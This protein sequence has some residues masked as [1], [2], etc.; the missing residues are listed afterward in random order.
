MN[1]YTPTLERLKA[2]AKAQP[3][4][5]LESM[6]CMGDLGDELDMT[7]IAAAAEVDRSS[8]YKPGTTSTVEEK[9]LNLLGSGVPSEAVASALGVTPSR[10][11]QLLSNED[12]AE[13]VSQLRYDNLQEHNVRDAS[14]DRIEDKLIDKLEKSMPLM[15][16]PDTILKAIT[17]INSAKRRGQ[18]AP[19]NVTNHQNI[20]NLVLP[21]VIAQ[22]FSTDINNQV[23][24]A[25]DQE[26]HT[27][28][29]SN[30]LKK[31]EDARETANRSLLESTVV[32]D[33]GTES[34]IEQEGLL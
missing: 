9:A 18:S 19:E 29:S 7:P 5:M 8:T 11:A 2:E 30:L 6:I 23:T 28:P 34:C 33:T 22:R 26:L 3:D 17:T 31:V 21:T 10:I 32:A 24:R 4:P 15:F 25:G 14:Y 16:K 20:V 27:M 13:R 1:T 12:F